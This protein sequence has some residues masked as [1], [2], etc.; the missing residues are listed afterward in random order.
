MLKFDTDRLK[1]LEAS[2]FTSHAEDSS[3]TLYHYTSVNTLTHIVTDKVLFVSDVR[4]MNDASELAHAASVVDW[5]SRRDNGVP[6]PF[7][8]RL[9]SLMTDMSVDAACY[10][11]CFSEKGSRLS[12]WRAYCRAG[13]GVSIGFSKAAL[14]TQ[15]TAQSFV[16]GKCQYDKHKQRAIAL[17]L[18]HCVKGR[19]NDVYGVHEN[20]SRALR[21][22]SLLK[23]PAFEEER[24][25]RVISTDST[26]LPFN[27]VHYRIG[28]H[29]LIP[30]QHFNLPVGAKGTATDEAL[31]LD[32][33]IL[34]PT[35]ND[36]LSL[37]SLKR[38]LTHSGVWRL[39]RP[40]FVKACGIPLRDM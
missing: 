26:A 20:L 40:R 29:M 27:A 17:E 1:K 37:H 11:A 2:L 13:D 32:Q 5:V 31:E 36:K 12:Q 39:D 22:A 35:V 33:V 30:Y 19:T 9:I 24:E 4:F 14:M 38:Y 10:V 18:L 34:G 16:L 23:N 25:W 8:W 6:R 7:V 28:R 21:I 3:R 15:A